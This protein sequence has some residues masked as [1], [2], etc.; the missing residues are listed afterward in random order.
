[1]EANRIRLRRNGM[2]RTEVGEGRPM[3]L[4]KWSVTRRDAAVERR[5]RDVRRERLPQN[6]I[7]RGTSTPRV[8][9][10]ADAASAAEEPGPPVIVPASVSEWKSN[11][12]HSLT[13]AATT[14]VCSRSRKGSRRLISGH[15]SHQQI[16]S[17]QSPACD[18]NQASRC[19]LQ[20][21][22][23]DDVLVFDQANGFNRHRSFADSS[24]RRE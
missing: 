12:V 1:M 21:F 3:L 9:E 7:D 19:R 20:Y 24:Q 14:M 22:G 15:C 2:S 16:T 6:L 18:G 4:E 17:D 5:E 23:D 11:V 13:L 10:R 8:C